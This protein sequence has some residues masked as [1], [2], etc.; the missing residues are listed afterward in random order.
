MTLEERIANV[1]RRQEELAALIGLPKHPVK[2]KRTQKRRVE[3][4]RIKQSILLSK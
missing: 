2:S 4:D 3:Q 1:E